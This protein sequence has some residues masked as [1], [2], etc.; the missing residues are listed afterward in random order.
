MRRLPKILAIM[1]R[2]RLRLGIT[3]LTAT[4]RHTASLVEKRQHNGREVNVNSDS[5][6]IADPGFPCDG[7][8][9]SLWDVENDGFVACLKDGEILAENDPYHGRY[10]WPLQVGKS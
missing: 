7:A 1:E 5:M 4:V 9:D 3:P 8:D 2:V 6:P 10:N